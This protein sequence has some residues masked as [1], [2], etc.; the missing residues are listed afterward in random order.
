MNIL[1]YGESSCQKPIMYFSETQLCSFHILKFVVIAPIELVIIIYKKNMG[2]THAS[3]LLRK[4]GIQ[5]GP[6]FELLRSGKNKFLE[7]RFDV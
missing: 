4:R 5:C 1:F 7:L 3:F 2:N 6:I